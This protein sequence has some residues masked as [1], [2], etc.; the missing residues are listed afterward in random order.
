MLKADN[1]RPPCVF[2]TKSG[3]LYF[4]EPSGPVQACNGTGLPS[5]FTYMFRTLWVHSQGDTC[6]YSS[7]CFTCIDV[8]SLVGRR[9]RW[10]VERERDFGGEDKCLQNF[11]E[12]S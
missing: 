3:N 7:V 2:V 9:K 12:E 10:Y 1:L 5:P 4:L 6:V 11:G 8:S